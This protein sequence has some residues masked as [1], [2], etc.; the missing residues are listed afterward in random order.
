MTNSLRID[1]NVG[2]HAAWRMGTPLAASL[3]NSHRNGGRI[4]LIFVA[5]PRIIRLSRS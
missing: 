3:Q 4:F 5:D 1:T 2:S